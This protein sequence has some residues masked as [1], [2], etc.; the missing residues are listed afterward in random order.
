MPTIAVVPGD[1]VGLEC[2]DEALRVLRRVGELEGIQ[3]E[4]V[5]YP[6]GAD[7]YLKTGE[8]MPASVL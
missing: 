7:H 3:F 2:I 6:W 1:G 8:L 4:T 5:M